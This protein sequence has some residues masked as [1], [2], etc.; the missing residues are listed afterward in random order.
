MRKSSRN[1]RN[2]DGK[3]R[4][5][6]NHI[7][8]DGETAMP[9]PSHI[10][11]AF[12]GCGG[13]AQAH[14]SGIQTHAPQIKVTAAVDT[15]PDR[16]A[17]MAAQTGAQ[18]FASLEDALKHGDFDAVDIMLPHNAHEHAATLAF[19]AGKHVVLEKP[20]ATTLDACDRILEAAGKAGTVFMIA[21]QSQ[22]WPAAVKTQQMIRNGVI[23]ELITE[24]PSSTNASPVSGGRIR[25]VSTRQSRAAA[26]ASTASCIG[27]DHCGCG[28]ARSMRS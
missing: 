19:A 25:G 28:W 7:E 23:G 16:A 27:Y 11:M 4:R 20:M 26:S 12:V 13:I 10:K 24:G 17:A 3:E 15:N 5:L 8:K 6:N 9:T 22:Y 21:E 18:S 14:W 2:G 1:W